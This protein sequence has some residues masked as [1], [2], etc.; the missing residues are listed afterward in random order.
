MEV[1]GSHVWETVRGSEV[2]EGHALG[3]FLDLVEWD[4][5][6]LALDA[7]VV[8]DGAVCVAERSNE[9]LVPER[10]AVGLVVE[11]ADGGVG[12]G[13]DAVADAGYGSGISGGPL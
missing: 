13:S 4:L 1:L 10:R 7:N 8:D 3:A 2:K 12:T 5:I 11:E 6:N 9:E